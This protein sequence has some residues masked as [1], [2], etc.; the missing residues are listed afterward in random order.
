VRYLSSLNWADI[1][2]I[3]FAVIVTS[4]GIYFS[5]CSLTKLGL[6]LNIAG[7]ILLLG[8]GL[9]SR[10]STN[11]DINTDRYKVAK[12]ISIIGVLLILTGFA[13]QYLYIA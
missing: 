3:L 7:F 11:W 9:P 6:V 8:F 2:F 4:A 5:L 10:F 12:I 1:F 13:L